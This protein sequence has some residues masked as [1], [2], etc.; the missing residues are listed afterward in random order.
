MASILRVNSFQWTQSL[1]SINRNKVGVVCAIALIIF[2]IVW[3]QNDPYA[4]AYRARCA[5]NTGIKRAYSYLSGH[6]FENP[7][8]WGVNLSSDYFCK[9]LR[10]IKLH[11]SPVFI[12][13][14]AAFNGSCDVSKLN[15]D[16]PVAIPV[17]VQAGQPGAHM[18]LFMTQ[19]EG[20][21]LHIEFYDAK[22]R[23]IYD[24]T[25]QDAYEIFDRLKQRC[26]KHTFKQLH[27]PFQY[28][29][30]SCGAFSWW[31]FEEKLK[32]RTFEEIRDG[33]RPNIEEYRSAIIEEVKK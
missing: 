3:S 13:E 29:C 11:S 4:Y 31:F 19:K 6:S 22:A 9:C 12:A 33:K 20:D 28:D 26:T 15:L 18:V 1:P 14:S 8:T 23:S 5:L 21:T 16:T 7:Q 25:N 2:K 10:F 27:Q 32:G 24:P 30:H 17:I